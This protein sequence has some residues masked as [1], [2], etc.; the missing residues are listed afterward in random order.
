MCSSINFQ[1]IEFANVNT[2]QIQ[3]LHISSINE[4]PLCSLLLSRI[5]TV[6]ISSWLLL[7][8]FW[9]VCKWNQI[10]FTILV[11][12]F[13]CSML[14]LWEVSTLLTVVIDC[15]F[16]AVL[17]LKIY[18]SILLVGIWVFLV[19]GY[20]TAIN[21]PSACLLVG[22]YTH[23]HTIQLDVSEIACSLMGYPCV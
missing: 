15:I 10:I 16:I 18:L 2:V 8:I 23:T 7:P 14:Y 17:Y 19:W 13:F 1:Q 3:K 9:N 11:S 20:C 21:I 4:S 6:S 5:I 12:D 22:I